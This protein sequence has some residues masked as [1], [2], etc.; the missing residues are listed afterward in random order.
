MA[1]CTSRSV[2]V[3][4]NITWGGLVE[5]LCSGLQIRV[6]RFD[7]GTRLQQNQ[8]L[9]RFFP[10][11]F[12][13]H[14]RYTVFCVCVGGITLLNTVIAL[15]VFASNFCSHSTFLLFTSKDFEHV[16]ITAAKFRFPLRLLIIQLVYEGDQQN[17]QSQRTHSTGYKAWQ[18]KVASTGQT[19]WWLLA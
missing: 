7:S 3:A 10:Q 8:A 5:W 16:A 1:S 6:H 13:I 4:K 2:N 14:S 11:N 17:H 18:C 19:G 12:L 9:S 15:T